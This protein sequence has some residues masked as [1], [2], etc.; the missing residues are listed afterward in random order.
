[1]WLFSAFSFGCKKAVQNAQEDFVVNLITSNIWLVTSFSEN[2]TNITS[3]FSPYE[4]KFNKD[5]S[6]YGIKT[7]ASNA[8]GTWAGNATNL[9]ITSAFP[10]GPSPLDKLTGVWNITKTTLS[11]VKANR[12][13]GSSTY[14]LE[15]QKK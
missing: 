13:D 8:V 6:V 10:A 1:M 4:F 15:L 3:G 14:Y 9:T 11:S 2:S 5:G 7:G 12:V